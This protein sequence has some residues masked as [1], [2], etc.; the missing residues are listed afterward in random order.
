MRS[1]VD[2]A[3]SSVPVE[4]HG[5]L[6]L[7][8]NLLKHAEFCQAFSALLTAMIRQKNCQGIIYFIYKIINKLDLYLTDVNI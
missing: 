1:A 2:A 7:N 8:L 3:H 4:E 6:Q 5:Q